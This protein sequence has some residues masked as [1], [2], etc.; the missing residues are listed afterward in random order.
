MRE[1]DLLS[2]YTGPEAGHEMLAR[3]MADP[4]SRAVTLAVE[5]GFSVTVAGARVK[6]VVDRI[7]TIAA[8]TVLIDYKTNA[9]LD[10]ALRDAYRLQLRIYGLA[11]HRGLLP[12]GSEPRL[13]LFD[14]RHGEAIEFEPDDAAVES[15]VADVVARI[16][17]GDFTLGPEHAQRPCQ[18][19]A[20]API[21]Q[22]RRR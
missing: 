7:A 9:K 3:Y 14:L 5:V 17:A 22:N 10:D 2:L 12:G 13:I 19:C 15:R 6:G 20:Y 16:R 18:L 4:L 11:A 8:Q 21:C 1:G